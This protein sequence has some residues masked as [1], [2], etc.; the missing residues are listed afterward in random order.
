VPTMQLPLALDFCLLMRYFFK[1]TANNPGRLGFFP[2]NLRFQGL[3]CN[4]TG[5]SKP[6]WVRAEMNTLA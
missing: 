1:T 4:F 3:Y 6:R 5:G 2:F